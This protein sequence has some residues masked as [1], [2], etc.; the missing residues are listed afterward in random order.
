MDIVPI[1]LVT[2]R[3]GIHSETQTS[4]S[5]PVDLKRLLTGNGL[6][7]GFS[8]YAFDTPKN[9]RKDVLIS[10]LINNNQSCE[11]DSEKLEKFRVVAI[12]AAFN[13]ADILEASIRKLLNQGILVYVIDNWSTDSTNDILQGLHEKGLILGFERYPVNGPLDYLDWKGLLARK[14]ELTVLSRLT[15]LFITMWMKCRVSPWRSKSLKEAIY[16]ADRMGFNAID[17][18]QITFVPIDDGFKPDLDFEKYFLHYRPQLGRMS[19]SIRG[20]SQGS[21][22][23]LQNPADMG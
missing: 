20:K 3:T 13:E 12:I 11:I 16:I 9:L 8:G 6:Q 22:P 5:H 14:E 4:I 15:G 1:C 2:W 10:V 19:R 17:H 21:D 23:I 18:T 7:V